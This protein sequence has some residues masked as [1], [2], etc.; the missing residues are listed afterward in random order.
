MEMDEVVK[1]I[2]LNTVVP[3]HDVKK[4][5]LLVGAILISGLLVF[6]I[7]ASF[8][9]ESLSKIPTNVVPPIY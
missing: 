7:D 1:M 4:Q 3:H 9:I 2:H 8:G 6:L 5:T